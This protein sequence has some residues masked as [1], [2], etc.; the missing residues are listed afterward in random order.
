[1]TTNIT[2]TSA[3]DSREEKGDLH[4]RL[5]S[6]IILNPAKRYTLRCF[7]KIPYTISN[8][9]A[10]L[11][12]NT[13]RYS[14]DDEKNY[15]T[16][17]FPDGLYTTTGLTNAV[18]YYLHTNGHYIAGTTPAEDIYPFALGF[19]DLT[20]SAFF[21]TVTS[22][23]FSPANTHID[24]TNNGASTWYSLLGFTQAAKNNLNGSTTYIGESDVDLLGTQSQVI[25]NCNLCDSYGFNPGQHVLYECPWDASPYQA[26]KIPRSGDDYRT[27]LNRN[28]IDEVVVQITGTDGALLKFYGEANDAEI[29]IRLVIEEVP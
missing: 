2:L 12:N 14:I 28:I 27:M 18:Q 4:L 19:N 9:N 23:A 6:R 29:R 8:I 20:G 21:T 15:S 26:M 22:G 3:T 10:A 17:T 7:G 24:L 11:G 1:M 25:V 13:F 16:V 5:P